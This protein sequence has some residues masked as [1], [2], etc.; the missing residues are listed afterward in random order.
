[1]YLSK[2][3]LVLCNAPAKDKFL[4]PKSRIQKLTMYKWNLFNLSA[5][6]GVTKRVRD[7]SSR[8]NLSTS[9][10]MWFCFKSGRAKYCLR[11]L[12]ILF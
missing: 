11:I 3:L 10:F 12:L 1:M 5:I 6:F 8:S 7:L 2:M 4:A 9:G